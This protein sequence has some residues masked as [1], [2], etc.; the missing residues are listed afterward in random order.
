MILGFSINLRA[1]QHRHF[2]MADTLSEKQ[3]FGVQKFTRRLEFSAVL[4]EISKRRVDF[5]R[6]PSGFLGML[7]HFQFQHTAAHQLLVRKEQVLQA[8]TVERCRF[9]ILGFAPVA[10]GA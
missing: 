1:S 6:K 5:S 7:T 3:A 2:D 4:V 9:H 8:T 10:L